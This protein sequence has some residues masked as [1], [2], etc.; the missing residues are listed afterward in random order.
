MSN[1]FIKSSPLDGLQHN[2]RTSNSIISFDSILTNSR[3]LDKLDL[4]KEDENILLEEIT[5]ENDNTYADNKDLR[6]TRLSNPVQDDSKMLQLNKDLSKGNIGQTPTQPYIVSLPASQFPSLKLNNGISIPNKSTNQNDAPLYTYIPSKKIN[7]T[8]NGNIPNTSIKNI[9]SNITFNDKFLQLKVEQHYSNTS[10]Y[11]YIVEE[12]TDSVRNI[13]IENPLD[14]NTNPIFLRRQNLSTKSNIS[15]NS[16]FSKASLQLS[17][18]LTHETT[19][20]ESQNI[21]VE[22]C[23]TPSPHSSPIN[24]TKPPLIFSKSHRKKNSL[25]SLKNLFKNNKNKSSP[26]P[27]KKNNSSKD[28]NNESGKVSNQPFDPKIPSSHYNNI[29]SMHKTKSSSKLIFSPQPKIS[30]HPNNLH[31]YEESNYQEIKEHA[32]HANSNSTIKNGKS[33][34]ISTSTHKNLTEIITPIHK[35]S[36]S[37]F[38]NIIPL[39]QSAPDSPVSSTHKPTVQNYISPLNSSQE[40]DYPRRSSY[41]KDDTLISDAINMRKAGNLHA[42]ALKLRQ[43]CQKGNKTAFL[44]YGLALRYGY[45]TEIDYFQSFYYI[46]L[47]TSIKSWNDEVFNLE[48][49]PFQLERTLNESIPSKLEE[50]L[51]PALFECGIAYLKG[52]GTQGIDEYKGL[53]CLEKAASMGH[54]DSMCLSGIIWSQDPEINGHPSKSTSSDEKV[55]RIKD[56]VKAA[57]WFRIAKR[58]GA[59]LIGSDWIY[60]KKYLKAAA[61]R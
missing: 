45:G 17:N 25:S 38:N 15:A 60:K 51:V 52:Y 5:K 31:M 20:T 10:R 40:N 11:S 28:F 9:L 36:N 14:N 23:T 58:R 2:L 57:A 30:P 29:T 43:A 41:S 32:C 55:R 44:L 59:C 46:K 53:K 6:S 3:L 16:Q 37:A 27:I 47:A 18:P 50:P 24:E 42:S 49:N 4:S 8:D 26:E 21:T 56:V 48:I 61:N 1:H 7:V 39:T 19:I 35:R 34:H 22:S 54:V 13:I 12:D 33:E